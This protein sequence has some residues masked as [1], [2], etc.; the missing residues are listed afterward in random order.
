MPTA[1][2]FLQSRDGQMRFAH[3]RRPHQQQTLF[4][5]TRIIA[6]KSLRQHLVLFHRL[7]MFRH[8]R[9]SV[10][11]IRVVIFK[12]TMFISFR[13]TRTLH[14]PR[15]PLLH[16]A[17]ARRSHRTRRAIEPL[18]QPPPRPST[19]WTIFYR[20]IKS[21]YEHAPVTASFLS[22]DRQCATVCGRSSGETA[23]DY[24]HDYRSPKND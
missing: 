19:K 16:S 7:F 1:N 14:H 20:H 21:A 6:H 23:T 8:P 5:R 4:S 13:Y 12:I 18:L 17:I 24:S 22:Q 10:S 11:K 9:L 3:T 15:G 2:Q